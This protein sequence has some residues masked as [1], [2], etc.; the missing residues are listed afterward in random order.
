MDC[1]EILDTLLILN[2]R[3]GAGVGLLQIVK[4]KQRERNQQ[5]S[6]SHKRDQQFGPD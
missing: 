5:T 2:Q 4:A 1:I 6:D 3:F